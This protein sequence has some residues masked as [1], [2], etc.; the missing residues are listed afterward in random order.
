[1]AARWGTGE[2][3]LT[4]GG[5]E[6]FTA[7]GPL[8]CHDL[9]EDETC[10]GLSDLALSL[11][12]GGILGTF[13]GYIDNS[14]ISIIDDPGA[15]AEHKDHF[16]EEN[17]LSLLN[18]LTEIL[19]NADDENMSPFDTIPDTE[20][21]V[22]SKDRD[23]SLR[24]LG[25][26]RTPP[27]RDMFSMDGQRR[28]NSNKIDGRCSGPNWDLFPDIISSTPKRRNNHK[29]MRVCLPRRSEAEE[30]QPRSDGEDEEVPTLGDATNYNLL[31]F[32]KNFSV[33]SEAD[34]NDGDHEQ[35]LRHG[36]PCIINT[37]NVTLND[38]VKYMHP[39]CLPAITVCLESEDE[40][41]LLSDEV[42]LEIVSDRGECIKVPVV[43]E[44][45]EEMF[46]SESSDD[47]ETEDQSSSEQRGPELERNH[48]KQ[49]DCT[50]TLDEVNQEPAGEDYQPFPTLQDLS[51]QPP[52]ADVTVQ[53]SSDTDSACISEEIAPDC[54]KSSE[55]DITVANDKLP[56]KGKRSSKEKQSS[57]SK[58]KSKTKS[59]TEDKSP[60][61]P[62]ATVGQSVAQTP[63]SR[64][65]NPSLQ[66]SDFLTKTLD[67]VKESQIEHRMSKV[68]RTKARSRASLD[69]SILE[70]KLTD[71]KVKPVAKITVVGGIDTDLEGD[72]KTKDPK[73]ED[74]QDSV[75][76]V[77]EL[78]SD[79]ENVLVS[80]DICGGEKSSSNEESSALKVE[81]VQDGDSSQAAKE[82]KPKSLSLS[83]YRKRLQ[84]R[85]PNPDRDNEKL[86]SS[87]WPSVPEPPTELAELPCLMAPT[88]TNKPS[89]E[90]KT[91]PPNKGGSVSGQDV[92]V[93]SASA[94]M[95]VT[96]KPMASQGVQIYEKPCEM[97]M[98]VAPPTL[99]PQ[100][101][102]PS[103]PFY[104][105]AWPAVPPHP[106]FYPG[107]PPL[108]V[109]PHY[110]NVMPS[111]L[112]VQPPPVI[113]WPP[114]PPPPIAMPPVHP[115][116]WVSGP[117]T[118]YWPN[119]QG[120]HES[121]SLHSSPENSV[122]TNLQV[123]P[124]QKMVQETVSPVECRPK[125]AAP[126]LVQTG[127]APVTKLE[128]GVPPKETRT[129]A[130]PESGK[131]DKPAA[132]DAIKSSLAKKSENA[133]P[134]DCNKA[135]SPLPDLK[136]A[137]Q[138][139]F[140]I[141]EI[142]KKAQKLG[143]QIKPSSDAAI[144]NAQLG[145]QV[146]S[147][148]EALKPEP[149]KQAVLADVTVQ[150]VDKPSTQTPAPAADQSLKAEKLELEQIPAI[151]SV[152]AHE[153]AEEK[154]ASAC[155]VPD[156]KA[157]EPVL[158][159]PAE[160]LTTSGESFQA[161]TES[162]L[163][164]P[165]K[166]FTCEAGIEATDLTSLLEQFEKSEAKV[167]E[168]L[169]QSPDKLAVGNSGTG[170]TLEKKINE[171]QL[172][173]EL[174]N[175][176]GL[177]P[178][179]T[180]PH[181]LWKSVLTGPLTVKSKPLHGQEKSCSPLKTTKLIEPKPLPQSLLK[182]RN[183]ASSP[184]V[185]SPPIHVASGDHDY[186]ILS[187][188][189]PENQS[190][191]T[192]EPPAP[193]SASEEGSRWNVKHHQSITIKPIVPFHKR[194]QSK[195]C[196]KQP[197]PSA[198]PVTSESTT[199][200]I[201][202]PVA[203][204]GS[205]QK[206]SKDPLD[207]RTN[208]MAESAVDS[209]PGSVLM[210]PDSSPCRSENGQ[211]RTDL[212]QGDASVSRRALRCYRKYKGSPSPQKSSWRGRS[213]GSRS[214]S[215]SSSSSRSRSGSPASKRRRTSRYK[216]RSR[217][218]SSS[219]SSYTTSSSS[220]SSSCSSRSCSPSSSRSRSR[221]R[222]PDRRRYRSR[223]RRCESRESYNRRRIFQKQQA[224]E[225][226]RVVYIGKINS[227]MTRSELRRRFSIFGDIEEC[228]IHFREQGDNYGFVT[229]RCT[230]EAFAAIENGHKLRLPDELPFDLCFGGRRQFC[231]SNY[232]D[233]DSNRDD[234]DPAPVR[235]KFES[236]DFDTLL[237]QAQKSHRR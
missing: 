23:G 76:K 135:N 91:C 202:K 54:K 223:S 188:Q 52:G 57:K 176:A 206:A 150:A 228:T 100:P 205:V 235:S 116:G 167:E 199:C 133:L 155:I 200:D 119:A 209:P 78:Q 92:P 115:T 35:M 68:S 122:R 64:S 97:A 231:K 39:Y 221:S 114:F 1:M 108:P 110:P 234:F 165:E 213:S 104:P 193:P 162:D 24:L 87:K 37:E 73:C 126:L 147:S 128:N 30:T 20:L 183:L 140:K 164:E 98:D 88:Q 132:A 95:T 96:P 53:R 157:N 11:D 75:V 139:V 194:Q 26:S 226:R 216:S 109:V 93:S 174:V 59:A 28:A 153:V 77:D 156:Q 38:L 225:E 72:P 168:R 70:K 107:M 90:V 103:P 49:I 148:A 229:Y 158:L 40:E 141:M 171:K 56:M 134:K 159:P 123:L 232:A 207:H 129:A 41:N 192:V 43:V 81:A 196:P 130:K 181:Q 65:S 42:F 74:T 63:A 180:P 34:N 125:T 19:D 25:L 178:P 16:D 32:D 146:A 118:M 69:G 45:L 86:S 169:P 161:I 94:P 160:T 18:A 144:A 12:A 211:G 182:N 2:E 80:A 186:C 50:K 204:C 152:N 151:G 7:C 187:S 117:T 106:S 61:A 195:A 219:R 179:A 29:S 121:Q 149:P 175:T 138:V 17:E 44:P 191:S 111:V 173:P 203:P 189:R 51:P 89:V 101:N 220:R 210:S 79:K 62:E 222:S 224:I 208:I 6:L 55:P 212:K 46:C 31:S 36:T 84:H 8:Q 66:E 4:I 227:Q 163:K 15:Q 166:S 105:P 198:P 102:R 154:L 9:E 112:P 170:K 58:S 230:K 14:I 82:A 83:E 145:I 22:S 85:K 137:N 136:S 215:R 13:H 113:S 127:R 27:D 5:M 120:M 177:T 48:E 3:T 33:E 131:H 10:H 172:A 237:K 124:D 185:M 214:D 184:S 190:A 60:V 236:L 21:L 201:G 233:L 217:S 143:Y 99:T 67:Q 71:L 142:L 218:R 197:A 47:A